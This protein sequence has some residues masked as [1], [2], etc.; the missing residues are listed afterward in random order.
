MSRTQ[1]LATVS[2]SLPEGPAEIGRGETVPTDVPREWDDA[3]VT[4]G[5]PLEGDADE[6]APR[7]YAARKAREGQMAVSPADLA[8]MRVIVRMA[9]V[10]VGRVVSMAGE[11]R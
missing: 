11:S 2:V 1:S 9:A 4:G 10:L 6:T 3:V 7:K 5:L 8:L